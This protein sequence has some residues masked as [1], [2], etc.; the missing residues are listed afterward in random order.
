MKHGSSCLQGDTIVIEYNSKLYHIDVLEIKPAHAVTVIETD[1]VVDFAPPKDYKEPDWKAQQEAASS[2]LDV[3]TMPDKERWA[4][5]AER[6]AANPQ[7]NVPIFE[8][9]LVQPQNPGYRMY[10]SKSV[11]SRVH[12]QHRHVPDT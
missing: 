10:A 3:E 9:A 1:I 4:D 12:K 7:G 6:Q 5:E 8:G 2:A 11:T